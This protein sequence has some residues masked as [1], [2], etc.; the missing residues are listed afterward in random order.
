[1][2]LSVD[3]AHIGLFNKKQCKRLLELLDQYAH[4]DYEP[5]IKKKNL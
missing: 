4:R 5:V 3:D 1:M 2:K